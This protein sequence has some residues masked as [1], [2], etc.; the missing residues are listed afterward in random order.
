MS[1]KTPF[2]RQPDDK[3]ARKELRE[4]IPLIQMNPSQ[5]ERYPT[6]EEDIWISYGH[7]PANND[8]EAR[9]LPRDVTFTLYNEGGRSYYIRVTQWEVGM[10]KASE[11]N[12]L[13]AG[14]Q[15]L[16]QYQ[17]LSVDCNLRI[18]REGSPNNTLI[19]E[20]PVKQY[21]AGVLPT[22]LPLESS[23]D[24]PEGSEANEPVESSAPSTSG[25]TE[26]PVPQDIILEDSEP[27]I[28]EEELP[29]EELT[30]EDTQVL[31]KETEDFLTGFV[32]RIVGNATSEPISQIGEI[33]EGLI[34]LQNTVASL[35]APGVG[36]A[37]PNS[38][39]GEIR[40][41]YITLENASK[42]AGILEHTDD[43]PL[44][45][46]TLKPQLESIATVVKKLKTQINSSSSESSPDTEDLLN[47]IEEKLSN[48]LVGSQPIPSGELRPVSFPAYNR[49]RIKDYC[50]K[51]KHSNRKVPAPTYSEM[52]EGYKR[53]VDDMYQAHFAA[54]VSP[55]AIQPQD[56]DGLIAYFVEA[57]D[58][59]K[60]GEVEAAD[61]IALLDNAIEEILETT[62]IEETPVTIGRTI[63]DEEE[64]DI[65]DTRAGNYPN[66]VILDVVVRGL[67]KRKDRM[68]IRKP[69]VVRARRQ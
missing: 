65:Y 21:L 30:T 66:G 19:H 22:S 67:R 48:K 17:Y 5:I 9:S 43:T 69:A 26:T 35:P 24:S 18:Y 14:E 34:E 33:K 11:Y 56:L 6:S 62:D 55:A 68:V 25:Q 41:Y 4:T 23:I 8:D 3:S 37:S 52:E 42:A 12:R 27:P 49:E 31:K 36:D 60:R 38:V 45:D 1:S 16:V 2:V 59:M 46:E 61:N 63:A 40:E 39:L 44:V 10:P 51:A 57:V 50:E 28:E 13:R 47:E 32:T 29:S 53:Y 64:H 20:I 7:L 58:L 15:W 54:Q